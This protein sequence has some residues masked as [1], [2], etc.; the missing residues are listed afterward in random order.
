M[1]NWVPYNVRLVLGCAILAISLPLVGMVVAGAVAWHYV[2][3][4]TLRLLKKVNSLM[5]PFSQRFTRKK[6]DSFLV[7]FLLLQG[8][9]VPA[10]FFYNLWYTLNHGFSFTR[11]YVYHLLR[12]GPYF[13]SFA[14]AY[15]LCHKEG[16]AKKVGMFKS[17][18]QAYL[19][20]AWNWWIGFF[21]GVMPSTFAYGHSVNHH[22]YDNDEEDTVTTWDQ[23]RDNFLHWVA[24]LPRWYAYHFNISVFIQ[25]MIEGDR[26]LALKMVWGTGAYASILLVLY[27]VHPLFCLCYFVYPILE[28]S[29]LLSAINWAWHC[30]VDPDADNMYAYSVTIFGGRPETNIL[31]EDYHVVHHQYPGAHWT[32][33]PRLFEKHKEEYKANQATIFNDV[34]AI[35]IFFLAILKQYNVFAEK[36]VDMS[37]EMTMAQKEQLI[38]TRLRTCTW[39]ANA[40]TIQAKAKAAGEGASKKDK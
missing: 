36:F 33:H 6:E 28:A 40:N 7:P 1:P 4:I 31:N 19:G 15:T 24:F 21:F 38:K 26:K 5:E 27:K 30:F 29:L 18:Y 34:H 35:E 22:K 37:N 13:Q 17:E 20:S 39:G 3:P 32:E 23:P 8:V 12:I 9:F 2:D 14:Y 10:L 16:H 11:F 25:F